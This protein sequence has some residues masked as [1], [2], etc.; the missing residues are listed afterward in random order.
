MG[1]LVSTIVGSFF[2]TILA[3]LTYLVLTGQQHRVRQSILN[4]F[5]MIEGYGTYSPKHRA[6]V[7]DP[8]SS[9]YEFP[10]QRNNSRRPARKNNRIN[11]V[12]VYPA[13]GAPTISGRPSRL[14]SMPLGAG[15]PLGTSNPGFAATA[16]EASMWDE[17]QPANAA[18]GSALLDDMMPN[19]SIT[20]VRHFGA[21]SRVPVDS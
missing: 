10:H 8:T 14:P 1:T 5:G 17:P 13:S 12:A 16:Y 6:A 21:G 7:N 9:R 18:F 15:S 2:G 20:P 19:P 4:F 11:Q 3:V